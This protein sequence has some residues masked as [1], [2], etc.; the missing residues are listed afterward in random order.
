M[1]PQMAGDKV[2]G[3]YCPM[4]RNLGNPSV[5]AMRD[6]TNCFCLMGHSL[7]HSQF[8]AMKPDMIKTEVRFAPGQGDVKVEVWC[9]Q[10]VYMKAKEALGE[11]FHPTIASLI[12]CCMAGDAVV[13][14]GQQAAELRKLGVKNGA[15]MLATARQNAEL[16]GQNENLTEELNKWENRFKDAMTANQ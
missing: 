8:W 9:N 2:T 14:D 12:R 11:R 10:E 16:S 13:I 7:S 1:Q 4:C 3:A 15:E 5:Q 6:Q